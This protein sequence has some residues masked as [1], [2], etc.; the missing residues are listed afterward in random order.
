VADGNDSTELFDPTLY[1]VIGEEGGVLVA[2]HGSRKGKVEGA[3]RR[4]CISSGNILLS[5]RVA[6]LRCSIKWA[7]LSIS[8]IFELSPMV[9]SFSY[10]GSRGGR[11]CARSSRGFVS[12]PSDSG[13]G[14][15]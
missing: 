14:G 1:L 3:S 12:S 15:P 11:P 7:L 10:M 9:G 4:R 6:C 5:S 2:H 8:E 13:E